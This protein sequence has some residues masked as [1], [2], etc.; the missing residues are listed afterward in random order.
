MTMTNTSRFDFEASKRFIE[1]IRGSADT[2]L[3]F[4]ALPES[5]EAQRR[6]ERLN[7]EERAK[8]RRNYPGT[9]AALAARFQRM[10]MS[11]HAIFVALN[12]F[13]G[14]GR[15]KENLVAAHVLPLDL[16]GAPLP[17]AWKL[18]PH[19]I[20][21]T[22]P[23]RYQCFFV[24]EPTTDIASV[25][26]VARRL[27]AHYGG[28]PAVCDA[29]HV[30]RAPGF[31]HQKGKPFQVQVVLERDFE[32]PYKLSDF[33]FL[34]ELPERVVKTSAAGI[35]VLGA[36]LAEKLLDQLDV[37]EFSD[38]AS[39][40]SLAMALHA[41]SGGAAE[42]RDVFLDWSDEAFEKDYSREK[43]EV[44]W[45]SF[46]LDKPTL[47]GVGTLIKICREHGVDAPTMSK[48]SA[49]IDFKAPADEDESSASGDG[50]GSGPMLYDLNRARQMVE[51][52][53]S[54]VLAA[55][56]PL[57]QTGGRLVYPVRSTQASTDDEAVRRPCNA[58]T[59]Q[60]VSE[61]RMEL[62]MN[63]HAPFVKLGRGGNLVPW[64][65][66]GK[67]AQFYLAARDLWNVPTLHGIIETPTLRADGTLLNEPGYD[68]RSGLLLDLGSL[69]LP[70][71][72]S[73]PSRTE[74]LA[75]LAVLKE[76]FKDFPFVNDGPNG[77]SA[78]RS[79]MLST[80]LTGLVRRTLPAAPVHGVSAPTP[81]TGK[82]LA[83]QVSAMT[84]IGRP[85]TAMS[86]GP[87]PEEDE[88]RLF[89]ILMQGDQMVS[90][91]NVTR[92]IGGDALCTILT[93]PTW[94]SRVLG[95]SRNVSVNT[96]VL[97]TATGNNL[98]FAGDMTRRA[99]LCRMDARMESPEGRQFKRDLRTWVPEHRGQLV[100]AG[101][102]VLL[103]FVAAGRPGLA[104][105]PPYGSFEAWSNLVR[106]AL[107]WL[108][109]P[110]PC[111][112]REH[113]L[114][115]DPVKSQLS[116]FFAAVYQA[117]GGQWFTAGEL[118]KK[119]DGIEPD[120]ELKDIILEVVPK[121]SS[122]SL[123]VFLK[124]NENKIFGGL[125]LIAQVNKHKKIREYKIKE[126]ESGRG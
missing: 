110:D 63:E 28:D 66:T 3:E 106:G 27:A 69:K 94:Q 90:I 92:P 61:T 23:G 49:S 99:L 72:P 4:R 48:L 57:Y 7:S 1:I 62:F 25:E 119:T 104:K 38:N 121:A 51:Y 40:L 17:T 64:R 75:A 21:E 22:S 95:Q 118:F 123:G 14:N 65:A 53:E 120:D 117:T 60:E 81:G 37:S 105:L 73:S 39:W 50:L 93:E 42:V 80:V 54:C 112:T 113:I 55:G 84:V 96:N 9:L 122:I 77:T 111:L 58:L 101:L 43:N 6:L 12:E 103:A 70:P 59:I 32:P 34:P 2:V 89:S 67:L 74:A 126:P 36:D 114:A 68:P 79:V 56:A 82:S 102:T 45:N 29:T 98:A 47:Q 20:Q 91:D 85:I 83:V 115:D 10:N 33:G 44:R 52:A 15:K 76:P 97:L 11:G 46:R 35:G 124:T 107:V 109:E 100:G 19:W 16:D 125:T 31:Y 108:G 8:K 41:S 78:S 86:Q 26:D 18:P 87:S 71:I 5:S 24:I 116:A 30:F 13:D 88:K